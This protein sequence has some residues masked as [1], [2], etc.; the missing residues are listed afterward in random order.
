MTHP[1]LPAGSVAEK[2]ALFFKANPDEALDRSAAAAKFAL[3]PDAVDRALQPAVEAALVTVASDGELGRVWRAG[4]MLRHYPAAA[5]AAAPPKTP[6]VRRRRVLP[7]LDVAHLQVHSDRP[8]PQADCRKGTTR[9]DAVF[10]KLTA[11]GM[12]V[13]GI[14]MLYRPALLKAAESYLK[15][16]PALAAA[17]RLVVRGIDA[18]TCGVWRVPKGDAQEGSAQGAQPIKPAAPRMRRT[19]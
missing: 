4:P 14:P 3:A 13:S 12:C 1:T 5:G 10:G 11:D 16:R 6:G 9:Y 2:A 17:S 18:S 7:E 19:A 8:L 15:H